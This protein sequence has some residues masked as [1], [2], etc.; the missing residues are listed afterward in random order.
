VLENNLAN[1]NPSVCIS[2]KVR[3]LER[4][5]SAIFRKHL[6]PFDITESQLSILFVLFKTGGLTQK[7]LANFAMLKKSTINRNIA[8]LLTKDYLSRQNFPI[9][10]LTQKGKEFVQSVIPSWE[11]AMLEIKEMLTPKGEEALNFILSKTN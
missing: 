4:A 3:R 5:T 7:Q 8:R 6:L 11:I 2:A 10:Q 9:L 1:F